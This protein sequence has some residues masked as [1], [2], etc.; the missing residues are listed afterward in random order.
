M[1]DKSEHCAGVSLGAVRWT[2]GVEM[3]TE[4]SNSKRGGGSH[5]S[6]SV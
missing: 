1:E 5:S 2:D 6:G 3:I 4:R